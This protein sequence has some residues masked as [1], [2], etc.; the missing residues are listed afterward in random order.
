MLELRTPVDLKVRI[1]GDDQP[2]FDNE[3]VA[4][5]LYLEFHVKA[6]PGF[7]LSSQTFEVPGAVTSEK[8]LLYC[9]TP[10]AEAEI[11]YE[12]LAQ[13]RENQVSGGQHPAHAGCE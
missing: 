8:A 1:I 13:R 2:G 9:L 7:L 4:F 3:I 11:P 12:Y 6:Q 5:E 10:I